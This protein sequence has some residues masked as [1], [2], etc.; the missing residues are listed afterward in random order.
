VLADPRSDFARGIVALAKQVAPKTTAARHP[1]Q[2]KILS[3]AR[4]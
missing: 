3:F 4:A 1:K 2:R